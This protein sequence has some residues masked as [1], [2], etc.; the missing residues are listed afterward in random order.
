MLFLLL[1]LAKNLLPLA[2][3]SVALLAIPG[4]HYVDPHW[5]QT[6]A[7][8]LIWM[9]IAKGLA[10]F[11]FP[12]LVCLLLFFSFTCVWKQRITLHFSLSFS[13]LELYYLRCPL[14]GDIRVS[15]KGPGLAG[16]LGLEPQSAPNPGLGRLCRLRR[17]SP[18]NSPHSSTSKPARKCVFVH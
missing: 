14:L 12:S 16:D 7:A 9:W 8:S 18:F 11:T 1:L 3:P 6:Y 13:P 4:I 15:V 10:S 17:F 2:I 5:G